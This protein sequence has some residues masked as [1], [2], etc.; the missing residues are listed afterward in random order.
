VQEV[1]SIAARQPQSGMHSR[2]LQFRGEF[3]RRQDGNYNGGFNKY[4]TSMEDVRAKMEASFAFT[5]K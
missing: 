3:Q 5:R 4:C 1:S 2:L